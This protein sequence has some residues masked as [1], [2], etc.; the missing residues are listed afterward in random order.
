MTRHGSTRIAALILAGGLAGALA[1]ASPAAAGVTGP[2]TGSATIDGVTYTPA[3]DTPS[4]PVLLPQD[5]I[6]TWEGSTTVVIKDP[7]GEI[8]I[9]VG[10]ATI[11]VADWASDNKKKKKSK[12]S[13]DISNAWDELPVDLVGLYEATG[14]HAGEGGRCDGNVMVKIEGNPLG[15]V[16]GAVGLALTVLSGAGVVIAGMARGGKP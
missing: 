2:C 11:K 4:N 13:Y 14:S 10:P 12:G 7:S 15:T 1:I 8:G 5:G 6:A 9:V 3:N 16:P